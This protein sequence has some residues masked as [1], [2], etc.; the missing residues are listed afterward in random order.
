ML[1]FGI[2]EKEE[3]FDFRS[4]SVTSRLGGNERFRFGIAVLR[5]MLEFNLRELSPNNETKN[6]SSKSLNNVNPDS[7]KIARIVSCYT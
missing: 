3:Y 4:Q 5:N 2:A 7:D 1:S 6:M